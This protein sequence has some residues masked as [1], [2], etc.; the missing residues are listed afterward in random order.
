[1]REKLARI[2]Y[3]GCFLC[4]VGVVLL[5]LGF[6]W[7]SDGWT[8][9][10]CLGSLLGG[11]AVLVIFGFWEAYGAKEPAVPMFLFKQW[12]F[13]WCSVAM[14]CMGWVMLGQNTFVPFYFQ[15]SSTRL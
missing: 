8:S 6:T 12:N 4:V 11:L 1:M 10:K 5:L 15:V 13:A 2:D 7:S 9:G 14:F 3:L